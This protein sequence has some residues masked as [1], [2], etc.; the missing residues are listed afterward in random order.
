MY[1]VGVGTNE[2]MSLTFATAATA[3]TTQQYRGDSLQCSLQLLYIGKFI[4]T[5]HC[6]TFQIHAISLALC[7]VQ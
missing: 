3:A 6:G 7:I 1:L 4:G 5:F 2:A